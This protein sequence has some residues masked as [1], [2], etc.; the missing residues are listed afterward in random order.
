MQL[1]QLVFAQGCSSEACC[2]QQGQDIHYLLGECQRCP[3]LS[4][5]DP[6]SL[7][8]KCTNNACCR[9]GGFSSYDSS[10]GICVCDDQSCCSF[11]Y[12]SQSY[13][14]NG[15]CKCAQGSY[16]WLTYN[17]QC[18]P[19]WDNQMIVGN[20]GCKSCQSNDINSLFAVKSKTCQCIKSFKLKNGVCEKTRLNQS[21]IVAIAVCVPI[22]VVILV[23]LLIV[24]IIIKKKQQTVKQVNDQPKEMKLIIQ[25]DGDI[26]RE[27]VAENNLIDQQVVQ[28][29][30]IITE[31][32]VKHE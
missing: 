11:Q 13:Y 3:S 6:Q 15:N 14:S 17:T 9:L 23:T 31:I 18:E 24:A 5:F 1:L 27:E 20:T 8:C 12:G 7:K 22:S 4:D 2:Q 26:I 21:S 29:V 10:K 28:P 16:S 19:C 25:N 30:P 32:P